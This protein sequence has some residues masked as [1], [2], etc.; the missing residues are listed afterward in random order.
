MSR[1][2]LAVLDVGSNS[3]RLFCCEAVA[4]D[5]PRGRR[6]S[7]VIGLRRGAGSDGTLTDDALGRLDEALRP[8]AD[9]ARA[10][11]PDRVLA[12][13][14]SAVRDAPNRRAVVDLLRD[15]AGAE[16]YVLSGDDEA[17]L[18]FAGAALAVDGGRPVTVVDVGGGS[19]EIVTGAAGTRR[20][21]V[22]LQLGAV[23][24]TDRHIHGDP[25][26]PEEVAAV[27]ADARDALSRVL[28]GLGEPGS[29]VAVAG[30]A[31]TLAAIDLGGYDPETVHRHRLP[32]ARVEEIL[33]LLAS[34]A[35][36]ERR[37]VPGLDPA[38][39]GVITAGAA[40]LAT[41]M[42]VTAAEEVM[43]SER[44]ILDGAAM[45]AAG[46]LGETFHFAPPGE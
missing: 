30:T 33:S 43:V 46:R 34:L 4:P 26:A 44:D 25:P 22:S 6:W 28:P 36:D 14:T 12:I 38:R 23:R 29:L 7:T 10:F 31:T 20:H 39:A 1:G 40:I 3:L 5:G 19:T 37:E 27:R 15:R 32:R 42:E 8:F 9:R 17:S 11:G 18:S 45:A 35:L 21:A 24:Q 41:V 16:V 2:R 13:C